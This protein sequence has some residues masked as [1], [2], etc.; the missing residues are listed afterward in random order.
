[1]QALKHESEKDSEVEYVVALNADSNEEQ[2]ADSSLV[3]APKHVVYGARGRVYTHLVVCQP[4]VM[5]ETE[6]VR[7]LG[8]SR[9]SRGEGDGGEGGGVDADARAL[10]GVHRARDILGRGGGGPCR[11]SLAPIPCVPS[12]PSRSSLLLHL[13]FII[14]SDAYLIPGTSAAQSHGDARAV[15][16]VGGQGNMKVSV[17]FL[18]PSSSSICPSGTVDA[19]LI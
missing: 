7:T 19:C 2:D 1:M 6:G 8:A 3:K 13:L 12:L 4:E 18:V 16:Q 14:G 10:H 11:L 17:G 15:S 5:E 9:T